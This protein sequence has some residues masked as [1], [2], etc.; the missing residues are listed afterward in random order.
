[1]NNPLGM[2]VLHPLHDLLENVGSIILGEEPP[3]HQLIKQLSPTDPE[4]SK[5][6]H[7]SQLHH[8]EDVPVVLKDLLK[9]DNIW[10][11]HLFENFQLPF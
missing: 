8:D 4:K 2:K 5:Q 10:M 1:M 7:P 3:L 11:L 9:R 6:D